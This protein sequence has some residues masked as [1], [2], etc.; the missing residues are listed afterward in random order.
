MENINN[1]NSILLSIKYNIGVKNKIKESISNI[2]GHTEYFYSEYDDI[3]Y[4]DIRNNIF[5]NQIVSI[6]DEYNFE[7]N[8]NIRYHNIRYQIFLYQ[9]N[10]KY[11]YSIRINKKGKKIITKNQKKLTS[12]I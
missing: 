1:D 3:M 11:P 7:K 6:L 4:Y 12:L 8:H 9:Y 5:F 10:K 2:I